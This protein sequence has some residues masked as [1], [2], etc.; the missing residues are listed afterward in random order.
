MQDRSS[1]RP[2]DQSQFAKLM[3]DIAA[4]KVPN[5]EVHE[6]NPFAVALG[7]L[8]GAKGGKARALKLSPQERSE[9]ARD[10]A[11]ARWSK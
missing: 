10:A 3:V 8:G 4:G 2:R 9:I 5:D 6:K 11:K 7:R 1:K